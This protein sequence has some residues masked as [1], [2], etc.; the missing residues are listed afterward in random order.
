MTLF[1]RFLSVLLTD[2][3]MLINHGKKMD[4][5]KR[6]KS[7]FMFFKTIFY[8]VFPARYIVIREQNKVKQYK[9]SSGL[10]FFSLFFIFVFS[11]LG[12]YYGV[13]KPRFDHQIYVAKHKQ[14]IKD[15]NDENIH[16]KAQL[17]AY[18]IYSQYAAKKDSKAYQSSEKSSK[19]TSSG[20]TKKVKVVDESYSPTIKLFKSTLSEFEKGSPSQK[21]FL[22]S[23]GQYKAA[24][25]E[26]WVSEQ[27]QNHLEKKISDLKHFQNGVFSTLSTHI[28]DKIS[29]FEKTLQK[30]GLKPQKLLA[31]Y[32][33]QKNSKKPNIGSSYF[34]LAKHES[35]VEE[36]SFVFALEETLHQHDNL[37]AVLERVPFA[38]PVDE[39]KTSSRFGRRKDPFTGKRAF[40]HGID[41]S[42]KIGDPVY[43]TAPGVI[44]FAGRQSGYGKVIE[45]DHGLGIKTRYGHL[46]KIHVKKGD[47][48]K[49]RQKIA[50]LG[51]TG[52]S[53]GPHLHYE[54]RIDGVAKNPMK[55]IE[56]GRYVF[57]K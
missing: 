4:L 54:T 50:D 12:L 9:L 56:A 11:S 22:L 32:Q 15:I 13:M 5:K 46:N 43:S 17:G 10:Q 8:F 6:K 37:Y 16:L 35:L 52:R 53:T 49:F 7:F 47:L 1:F 48:V 20:K 25:H 40:H 38:L 30:A 27:H 29:L 28:N 24:L 34:G 14:Y 36:N 3:I 21:E 44:T 19:I 2:F 26:R 57:K 42:G 55:L 18:K 23:L 41:F 31:K 33:K 45:V 39:Y 51:N